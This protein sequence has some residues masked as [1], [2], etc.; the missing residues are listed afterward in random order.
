MNNKELL[1]DFIEYAKSR[2]ILPVLHSNIEPLALQMKIVRMV[3][4]VRY[5]FMIGERSISA[6]VSQL[7]E[8]QLTANQ[9][10]CL[11]KILHEN[12][13]KIFAITQCS[14]RFTICRTKY[15]C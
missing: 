12:L 15:F 9:N 7:K 2:H 1:I 13:Y 6:N 8:V 10:L 11:C 3:N 4:I 14:K 5:R